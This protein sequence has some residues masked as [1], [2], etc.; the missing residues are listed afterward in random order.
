MIKAFLKF[1]TKYSYLRPI[2]LGIKLQ[3]NIW[4]SNYNNVSMFINVSA[5]SVD[6]RWWT[7]H[8]SVRCLIV[9]VGGN[10]GN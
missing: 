4:N 3:S 9:S 1:L 7:D 2:Y 8:E 5:S 6:V 10:S